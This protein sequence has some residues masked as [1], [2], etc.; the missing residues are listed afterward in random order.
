MTERGHQLESA[1]SF[2]GVQGTADTGRGET[3]VRDLA[4]ECP[5]PKQAQPD[6]AFR[7]PHHIAHQLAGDQ[8]GGHDE[9]VELP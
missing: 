7:V 1:A 9:F 2:V 5:A 8:L 4:D 6:G 3:A